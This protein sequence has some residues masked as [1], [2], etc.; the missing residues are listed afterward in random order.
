MISIIIC[1]HNR[2]NIISYCIDSFVS[3]SA[4]QDLFEIIVVDNGS[5]DN[6]KEIVNTFNT[7]VKNLRYVFEEHIGLSHARNRGFEEAKFDWV[8]Y[9]D[10]DAKAYPDYVERVLWVIENH[11]FDCFGGRFF[12]WYLHPKPKW[13]PEE[14]GEFPLLRKDTGPLPSNKDVAGGVIVF[15][16]AILNEVKGF[17]ISL[18]MSGNMVGYGEEN[19]VQEQMRKRS[20]T[21]GFDPFLK[22][23]HL[24][25]EYKYNLKWHFKRQ[26]AK[27]KAER[28]LSV[29]VRGNEIVSLMWAI[30]VTFKECFRNSKKLIFNRNYYYQNYMLDSFS[31]LIKTI[32]RFSK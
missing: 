6:T 11:N 12:P 32:A 16:K 28:L 24:V 19:W 17:P 8:S 10:D 9:V 22:I 15:R 3:Q 18:G 31:Y 21:I 7:K 5:I 23:D 29:N 4:S 27:G 25:A 13:L 2:A 20:Y 30:G 1:T 14:F 26:Y